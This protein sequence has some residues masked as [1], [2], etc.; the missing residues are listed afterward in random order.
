VRA[1]R[2]ITVALLCALVGCAGGVGG[3]RPL[4][5]EYRVVAPRRQVV[6]PVWLAAFTTDELGGRLSPDGRSLLYAGDQKG[7]LDIWVKDLTTGIPRRLTSHV[8]IDTQPAWSP[9]GKRVVF[10]SMR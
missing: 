3:R 5:R 7:S 4:L 10:V 8:A 2:R 9:D 6:Q 1:H